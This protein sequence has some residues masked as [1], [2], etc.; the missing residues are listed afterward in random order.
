MIGEMENDVAVFSVKRTAEGTKIFAKSPM[1][2]EF[3]KGISNGGV[4]ACGGRWKG[5]EIYQLS[6]ETLMEHLILEHCVIN[7]PGELLIVNTLA[8]LTFLRHKGLGEGLSFTVGSMPCRRAY[9]EEFCAKA[10]AGIRE[11]YLN[12]IR[13]FED[14]VLVFRETQK[15]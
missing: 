9:L 10:K 12:Y 7:S 15:R 3:F 6:E 13:P 4:V 2:E 1:I 8:N 5:V 14:E 11:L